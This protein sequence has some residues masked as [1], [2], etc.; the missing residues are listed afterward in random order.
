MASVAAALAFAL[1]AGPARSAAQEAGTTLPQAPLAT[2]GSPPPPL[3]DRDDHP[4][5]SLD[6][7]LHAG[8]TGGLL[9]LAGATQLEAT[10]LAATRCRW[11]E[12]NP[13]DRWARRQLLWKNVDAASNLSQVLVIA[14]PVGVALTLGLSAR[15]VGAGWR[16]LA[17][18]LLVVTEAVAIATVLTQAA[19]LGTGRLRPDA[20]AAGRGGATADSRMSFWGGHS[21]FAFSAAAAATQVARLRGRPGWGWL[22]V[23]SFTAAAAT[24]Y[25]RLAGDRHWL[26]D[27]V[28]GAGVGTAVGLVVPSLV[29]RPAGQR[30]AAVTLAPA[31]GGFALLF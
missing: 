31:P 27:V 29:L 9:L 5:L 2:P 20:W 28:V 10:R 11:C 12:P 23:V 6:L 15:E 16:E 3:A 18:D 17:E 21:M 4:R 8:V 25:S 19:K 1:G 7:P 22:A 26:T 24:G 13:L 30:A 14:V